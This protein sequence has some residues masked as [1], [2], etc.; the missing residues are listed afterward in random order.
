MITI[1]N[2]SLRRVLWL[3]AVSGWGMALSHGLM[4][5]LLAAWTGM[6][7]AWLQVA[8]AAVLLPASWAAWL[9]MRREPSPAGVR[10]LALANFAWVAA[11]VWVAFGAGL[12][13]TP[14]GLGWVM[15]QALA[16]LVLAELEWSGSRTAQLQAG[17]MGT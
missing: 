15:L 9:A 13:L 11:S 16:V 2:S 3:D 7:I 8:A 17:V 4:A 10:L 6:P 1:S 14:L 5:G 12:A